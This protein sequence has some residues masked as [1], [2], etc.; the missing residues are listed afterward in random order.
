LFEDPSASAKR[1]PRE[2]D[3]QHGKLVDVSAVQPDIL[4]LIQGIP[5]SRLQGATGLSLHYFSLIRHS[6]RA[7]HSRRWQALVEAAESRR[8]RGSEADDIDSSR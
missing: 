2:W 6:E 5:L 3:E 4:P 1:E 7:P 8:H